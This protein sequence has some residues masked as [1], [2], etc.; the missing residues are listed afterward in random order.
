MPD[1]EEIV[2]RCRVIG[3]HGYVLPVRRNTKLLHDK[4]VN[5]TA[6]M[7]SAE[8]NT[9]VANSWNSLSENEKAPFLEISE[10]DKIR[11]SH[12]VQAYLDAVQKAKE[13]SVQIFG[14]EEKC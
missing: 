3:P 12:D 4:K 2:K 14:K 11:Y 1:L 9:L 13:N 8:R 6:N 5:E 10:K 7:T